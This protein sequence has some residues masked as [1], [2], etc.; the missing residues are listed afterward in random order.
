MRLVCRRFLAVE[1]T[2]F[3]V[4]LSRVTTVQARVSEANQARVLLKVFRKP[5]FLTRRSS[6]LQLVAR[7][8]DAKRELLARRVYAA[9]F[10]DPRQ[11]VA[12]TSLSNEG[13]LSESCHFLNDDDLF[14]AGKGLMRCTGFGSGGGSGGAEAAAAAERHDMPFEDALF[15]SASACLPDSERAVVGANSGDVGL[16]ALRRGE[17]LD[18]EGMRRWKV[19]RATGGSGSGSGISNEIVALNVAGGGASLVTSA[20][21]CIEQRDLETLA[22]TRVTAANKPQFGGRRVGWRNPR[23]KLQD[24]VLLEPHLM[25][26]SGE[27]NLLLCD[28]RTEDLVVA[29]LN[30]NAT[31]LGHSYCIRSLACERHSRLLYS[32]GG[33]GNVCLWDLRRPEAGP[34]QRAAAAGSFVV[35][36]RVDCDNVL[37]SYQ[38]GHVQQFRRDL[39]AKGLCMGPPGLGVLSFDVRADSVV[40][41]FNTG[42]IDLFRVS[43]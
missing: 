26:V 19:S 42:Q 24:T 25:A 12:V 36:V 33:D 31:K 13:F 30:S 11:P 10:R 35:D 8:D 17:P 3:G 18:L 38:E 23:G 32:G 34:T 40:A 22:V 14:L 5:L 39:S 1:E 37:V 2:V 9:S 28:L 16:L 29:V 7:V 15:F 4:L 6:S 27:E 21:H 43:F 20:A 41:C